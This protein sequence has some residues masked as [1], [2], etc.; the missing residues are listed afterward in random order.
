ME[1]G[2]LQL[3][4][5]RGDDKQLLLSSNGHE[6]RCPSGSKG[7]DA[8]AGRRGAGLPPAFWMN[9]LGFAF[10]SSSGMPS[11]ALK[12]TSKPEAQ[13]DMPPHVG[14]RCCRS[15]TMH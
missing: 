1:N 11:V 3:G 13:L 5:N 10:V 9:G 7:S 12:D 14:S 4:S 8:Q 6:L 2:L 15:S